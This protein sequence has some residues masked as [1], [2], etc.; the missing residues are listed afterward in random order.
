[1]QTLDKKL[2]RR[3]KVDS[4]QLSHCSRSRVPLSQGTLFD[5]FGKILLSCSVEKSIFDTNNA[6][7]FKGGYVWQSIEIKGTMLYLEGLQLLLKLFHHYTKAAL[8][9]MLFPWLLRRR[10]K[11][12]DWWP[13]LILWKLWNKMTTSV[14]NNSG[15]VAPTPLSHYWL[16]LQ[17]KMFTAKWAFDCWIYT[18][19]SKGQVQDWYDLW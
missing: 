9:F 6:S 17:N 1:M 11:Q 5:W 3:R 12:R 19:V 16:L 13:S 8:I 18:L 15:S 4:A 7:S 14:N 10:E 2:K